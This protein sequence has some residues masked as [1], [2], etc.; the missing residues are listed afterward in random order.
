L[1][2]VAFEVVLVAVESDQLMMTWIVVVQTPA[3]I[4]VP[5]E[6]WGCSFLPLESQKTF[7]KDQSSQRGTRTRC[8]F[9]ER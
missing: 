1:D 7:E 3:A 5:V 8:C 6:T 4:E 2:V 9:D